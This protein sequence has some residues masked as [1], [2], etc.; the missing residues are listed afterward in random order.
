G[1]NERFDQLQTLSDLLFLDVAVRLGQL[2]AQLRLERVK[3]EL[4]KQVADGLGADFGGEGI[5][6]KRLLRLEILVL[7][8][9]LVHLQVG[10]ARLKHDVMLEIKDALEIL[11]RHVEQEADAR[12]QRLQEPDMGNGRSEL[13]VSHALAPHARQRHFNRALLADYAFVLHALVLAAQALVVL[14]RPEDT[15]AEQAVA[16][17]LEGAVVDRLRLFDLAVGPRHNLFRA[18]DRNPDLVEDLRRDLRA[19]KIHDLLV[20]RVFSARRPRPAAS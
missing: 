5:V 15:R 16:L 8:E 9:K 3:I 10:H 11:Q 20:H 13:D 1:S 19:E 14:D 6:A 7:A 4:R 2:R 12:G 17:G 18:R